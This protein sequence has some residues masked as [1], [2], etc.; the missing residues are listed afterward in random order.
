MCMT[1]YIAGLAVAFPALR[2]VLHD[3]VFEVRQYKL[4]LGE[5]A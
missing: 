4:G 1:S 2:W 5:A 3:R